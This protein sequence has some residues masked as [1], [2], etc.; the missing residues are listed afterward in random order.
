[1]RQLTNSLIRGNTELVLTPMMICCKNLDTRPQQ[2]AN[3]WLRFDHELASWGT[4]DHVCDIMNITDKE[5]DRL[6]LYKED[7]G[8]SKHGNWLGN[9]IIYFV[10]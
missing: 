1:M 3:M 4:E 6:H 5:N 10:V 8:N 9:S 2:V 7:L